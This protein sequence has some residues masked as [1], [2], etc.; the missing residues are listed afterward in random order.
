MR[1]S[2][3]KEESKQAFSMWISLLCPGS[4]GRLNEFSGLQKLLWRGEKYESDYCHKCTPASR[5]TPQAKLRRASETCGFLWWAGRSFVDAQQTRLRG[6]FRGWAGLAGQTQ[7]Q[8]AVN[9]DEAED[10]LAV[11]YA[12]QVS[13]LHNR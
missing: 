6:R 5:C 10:V 9:F 8:A 7:T 12:D 3:Q 11:Q 13:I 4:A 2:G 1:Q